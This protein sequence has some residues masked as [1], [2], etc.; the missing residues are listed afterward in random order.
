MARA[1]SA[2]R[3]RSLPAPAGP[4]RWAER[5]EACPTRVLVVTGTI[6]GTLVGAEGLIEIVE[7]LARC[8]FD[9][10]HP[11]LRRR[12]R[13]ASRYG[14]YYQRQGVEVVAGPVDWP[15]WCDDRRYHYSHVLVSDE[16]LTTQ[17]WQLVRATQ[18]Q[19]MAVL[20]CERLP[21]R[22]SQA[23]GEATW[24]TEGTETVAEVCT[25]RLLRQVEGIAGGLVRERRGR[26]P[27]GGSWP[28]AARWPVSGRRSS[29]RV[30]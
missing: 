27:A 20:Y 21:F 7:T 8:R 5:D 13:A 26:Q 14:G 30:P 23:L 28:R 10:R 19:A 16:G 6:P 15:A 29:A 9:A 11:G 18:P 17:L 12:F 22:R 3:S 24:H 1:G 2:W 4:R 25:A